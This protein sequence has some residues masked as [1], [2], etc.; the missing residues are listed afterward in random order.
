[1]ES[2]LRQPVPSGT[3]LIETFGWWPDQGAIRL[4]RH[5]ARMAQSAVCLGFYFD[6]AVAR[7]IAED[8]EAHEPQRCR[9]TLAQDG[10][11][12]LTT[13]PLGPTAAHWRVAIAKQR[14]ASE[15]IWLRH[16]TTHRQQYD[17]ARAALPDGVDEMLFLNEHAEAC[18][19]TI[20]NLFVDIGDGDWV[21]PSVSCGVLP[22]ILREEMLATGKCREA[23][24]TRQM[25]RDAAGLC[26]GNSLRGLIP[27]TLVV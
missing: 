25:L 9:M 17:Q 14:L 11:I 10:A 18:E 27:T 4:D 13:A 22:G 24:V 16:K 20:T 6:A 1:M 12:H 7:R 2:A 15:D 23:V 8:I 5:F 26:M 19:G 3:Q 21:T